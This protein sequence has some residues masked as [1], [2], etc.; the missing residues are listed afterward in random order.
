MYDVLIRYGKVSYCSTT[1]LRHIMLLRPC[2][3][4][5]RWVEN[6]CHILHTVPT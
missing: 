2:R 5:L 6:Y 3:K 1:E 4:L